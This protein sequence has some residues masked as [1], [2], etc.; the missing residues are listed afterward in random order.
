MN[1]AWWGDFWKAHGERMIWFAIALAIATPLYVWVPDLK[2]EAS[3]VIV[4]CMMLAFKKVTDSKIG[5][6]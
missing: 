2:G 3:G 1:K 5:N 4:G 6:K